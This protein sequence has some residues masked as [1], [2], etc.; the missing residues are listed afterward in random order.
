MHDVGG[1]LS[2]FAARSKIGQLIDMKNINTSFN[3][4]ALSNTLTECEKARNLLGHGVWMVDPITGAYCIEN[5]SGEWKLPKEDPVSR[6]KYPQA[7]Y[8][9][10]TWLT[11]TFADIKTAIREL[12]RLDREIDTALSASTQKGG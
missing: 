9:T 7:F 8:P 11:Q 5:P 1:V 10:V 4:S 3:L 6:R 12:Q 2:F